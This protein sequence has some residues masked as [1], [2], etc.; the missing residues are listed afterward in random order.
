MGR[1]YVDN[2]HENIGARIPHSL[3]LRTHVEDFKTLYQLRN[4]NLTINLMRFTIECLFM[5]IEFDRVEL[6]IAVYQIRPRPRAPSEFHTHPKS[7]Q[8]APPAHH[9]R[10]QSTCRRPD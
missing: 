5:I 9:R 10:S 4:G 7:R 1:R 6:V 8:G 2:H 3:P